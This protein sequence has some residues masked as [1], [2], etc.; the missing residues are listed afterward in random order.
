MKKIIPF[1]LLAATAAQAQSPP[2][3]DKHGWS[4]AIAGGYIRT[5]GDSTTTAENLKAELN[6]TN[7][8]WRNEFGVSAANGH[9]GSDTTAEQYSVND[10][11]KFSFNEVDYAFGAASFDADR[12][13]GISKNFSES[14]GYGR[15]L[16]MT[17]RQTLDA[18]LGFGASQQQ[19]VGE[20]HYV[21]QP[22]ATFGGKY[23]YTFSPTSQFKQTLRTEV[24]SKNTFINPVSQLK[25]NIIGS[26]FAA[27]SYEVRYNTTVPEGSRHTDTITSISFGY[28]F[29]GDKP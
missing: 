23:V 28:G 20:A 6:Y 9:T 14:A 17:E 4:G 10:K 22:I 24:G 2:P 5:A 15:R 25:L 8:P 12:F 1:L 18:E 21:T 16:L 13:S 3:A 26:L 19:R 11:L 29:G 27:L 7:M